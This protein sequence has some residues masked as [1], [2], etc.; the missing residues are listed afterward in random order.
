MAEA[1]CFIEYLFVDLFANAKFS[2]EKRNEPVLPLEYNSVVVFVY[3]D[4]I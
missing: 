4:V 1:V 3:G 2:F